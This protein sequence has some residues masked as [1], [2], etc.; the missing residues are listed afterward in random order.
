LDTSY[1][2]PCAFSADGCL[3]ATVEMYG[4]VSVWEVAT[5]GHVRSWQPPAI[6]VERLVFSPDGWKLTTLNSDGTA[7]VWDLAGRSDASPQAHRKLSGP[8]L[9]QLWTDLS[10]NNA[11]QANRAI[12]QIVVE[13]SDAVPFLKQRL[14]KVPP[15]DASKLRQLIGDLG[16]ERYSVREIAARELDRLG[17]VAGP[18][19]E[20]ALAGRPA[21]D[22][23]D[24][25]TALLGHIE[26]RQ[27]DGERLRAS[28]SIRALEY[29]GTP[30]ARQILEELS[31]G[32]D[33]AE[34]TRDARHSLNRMRVRGD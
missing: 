20:E 17:D 21:V 23:R 4:K 27:W 13:A 30:A 18:A 26:T 24:R 22:L 32:A 2:E 11:E 7:L 34:I 29:A 9:E 25:L 14:S 16:S 12:W 33:G 10:G 1:I 28:R 5:G 19:L 3:L 31:K 15:P 8:E 6:K